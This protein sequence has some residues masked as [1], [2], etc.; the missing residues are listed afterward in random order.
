M[1]KN[2]KLKTRLGV[3]AVILV[4]L[5]AGI[6][7]GINYHDSI[8]NFKDIY[9]QSAKS[10][11]TLISSLVGS[12]YPGQWTVQ[13]SVLTKGK[14]SIADL[15]SYIENIY[16]DTNTHVSICYGD[17]R[18]ATTTVDKTGASLKGQ[19]VKS[20]I[21]D[22]VLAG[23]TIEK[24][25]DVGGISCAVSYNPIKDSTGKIIGIFFTGKDISDINTRLSKQLIT[26]VIWVIALSVL[27]L[28]CIHFVLK[29]VFKPLQYVEKQMNMLSEKDFTK[30]EHIDSIQTTD[31]VGSIA[32]A[33]RNMVDMIREMILQ[34][35]QSSESIDGIAN[36]T[37]DHMKALTENVEESV[38]ATEEISAGMEETSASTEQVN[39]SVESV[40]EM[41][42]KFVDHA[43]DGN[44]RASDIKDRAVSLRSKAVE[45]QTAANEM[46]ESNKEKV[47][48]ALE[49]SKNIMEIEKLADTIS[50]IADQTKLL[51]LNATI[52]A[53]RAGEAGRGF[54]VVAQEIQKL[55]LESATAVS[56]I[57]EIVST[58]VGSVQE[59]TKIIEDIMQ[60]LN[61]D[62]HDAFES[63]VNTGNVYEQ[64]S[65]YIDDFTG[66]ISK[67]SQELLD[68]MNN[69]AEAMGAIAI[70]VDESARGNNNVAESS[71]NIAAKTEAVL[72]LSEKMKEN[73]DKLSDYVEAF[74]Y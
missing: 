11:Y 20:E 13:S 57:Q 44:Q 12:E 32:M 41:L 47:K 60:Y 70:T 14:A 18:V 28:A 38:A 8:T 63:L 50:G 29:I 40:K 31:E 46:V 45:K 34:I 25:E 15:Q 10:D 37:Q 2:M 56:R 22:K 49:T 69:I 73:A 66:N 36:D 26:S 61:G 42:Q 1:G 6:L 19:S 33:S 30:E 23:E 59:L 58:A 53:S 5:V 3:M 51:A 74:H 67:R 35:V 52:E 24:V 43:E 62:V 9:V 64:D 48:A 27:A 54:N 4:I 68:D 17:V 65:E 7:T 39:A 21:A 71:T 16:K 72:S 55:S